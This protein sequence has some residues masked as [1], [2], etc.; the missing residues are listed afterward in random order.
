LKAVLGKN[1]RSS[2]VPTN[3]IRKVVAESNTPLILN[4]SG[5]VKKLIEL[6]AMERP[7]IELDLPIEWQVGYAQGPSMGTKGRIH[8]LRINFPPS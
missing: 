3:P 5:V 2:T 7:Q 4:L 6:P 8:L 1:S